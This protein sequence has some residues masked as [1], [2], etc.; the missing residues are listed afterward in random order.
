MGEGEG[1]RGGNRERKKVE[2]EHGEVGEESDARVVV[3]GVC[4]H[5]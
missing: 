1:E 4:P 5:I 2:E 3:C